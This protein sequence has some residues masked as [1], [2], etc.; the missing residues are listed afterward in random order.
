MKK[1]RNKL[2]TRDKNTEMVM[3]GKKNNPVFR[4]S[5]S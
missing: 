3:T 2:T 5:H 4:Q 1:K